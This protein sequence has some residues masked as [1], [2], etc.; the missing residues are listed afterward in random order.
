MLRMP[1]V[2]IAATVAAAAATVAA[3]RAL[4]HYRRVQRLCLCQ[5]TRRHKLV[6]VFNCGTA[7]NNDQ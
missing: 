6:S 2:A 5:P 4:V 3:L 7:T 1:E